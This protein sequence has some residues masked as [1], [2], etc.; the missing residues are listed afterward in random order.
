MMFSRSSSP[1]AGLVGMNRQGI[2]AQGP[3]QMNRQE[4]RRLEL[5]PDL[6]DSLGIRTAEA[7]AASQPRTLPPL[8]GCLA[9]DT[10]RVV[11]IRARLPGKIVSLGTNE[12]LPALGSVQDRSSVR[13]I[14]HG[15]RVRKGQLLAVVRSKDLGDKKLEFIEAVL[16][17]CEDREALERMRQLAGEGTSPARIVKDAERTVE[18]DLIN[19]ARAERALQSSRLTAAEIA[20]LRAE[21]EALERK[22][23]AC[24]AGN[25]EWA[26]EELCSPQDGVILDKHVAASDLVDATTDL[27]KIGDLSRLNVWIQVHEEHLP[28]LLRLQR[29][30]PWTIRLPSLP[31]ASFKGHLDQIGAVIDPW[32]RTALVSGQVDNSAGTL[33]VGQ[34][35][36]ATLDVPVPGDEVVVPSGAIVEDGRECIVF[37]QPDPNEPLFERRKVTVTQRLQDVVY[38]RGAIRPGEQVVAAGALLKEETAHAQ[39]L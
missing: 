25:A 24:I 19:V 33:R 34:F 4:V 31:G 3:A 20:A 18:G 14:R 1:G 6:L 7:K 12:T 27:F 8:N 21:G 38:V 13:A 15:D 9:L 2:L 39:E 37:V 26:C 28:G 35:V 5:P 16:R 10:N 11:R 23:L 36:T 22:E 30:I 17:L 29:P 32:Q